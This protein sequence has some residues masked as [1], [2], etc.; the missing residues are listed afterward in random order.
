MPPIKIETEGVVE[1]E[2][3]TIDGKETRQFF[4]DAGKAAFAIKAIADEC[5]DDE[6]M[7][8]ERV[9][10]LITEVLGEPG[11]RFSFFTVNAF[12]KAVM[13]V[14]GEAKKKIWGDTSQDE[15]PAT[16]STF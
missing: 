10:D 8:G 4:V 7:I 3:A 15:P 9:H 13:E 12:A 11:V 2:L 1:F 14:A 6:R 5:G 16:G